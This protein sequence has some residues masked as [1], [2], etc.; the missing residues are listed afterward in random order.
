M[1][2]HPILGYSK[3]H[4]GIDFAAPT[5]RPVRASARAHRDRRANGGYGNYIRI[6]HTN[7]YATAYAHLNTIQRGIREGAKVA[8]GQLIGTVGSTGMSTG[9]HLHYESEST[10]SRWTRE[11]QDDMSVPLKGK[12]LA[13]FEKTKRAIDSLMAATPAE[14]PGGGRT[15][16]PA[17]QRHARRAPIRPSLNATRAG[18]PK[19]VP[20]KA[21][22]AALLGALSRFQPWPISSRRL[23]ENASRASRLCASPRTAR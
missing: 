11:R 6:R 8:Q 1:R 21:P 3:M 19:P 13:A 9:P 10:A 18:G 17:R 4:R 22:F 5:G 15:G 12:A 16:G 2:R 23:R 14:C 7:R 20:M